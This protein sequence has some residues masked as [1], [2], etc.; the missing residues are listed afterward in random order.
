[1]HSDQYIRLEGAVVVTC[2]EAPGTVGVGEPKGACERRQP[3]GCRF[4]IRRGRCWCRKARLRSLPTHWLEAARHQRTVIRYRRCS[5]VR[6]RQ[7]HGCCQR[8]GTTR[9]SHEY[10]LD[11]RRSDEQEVHIIG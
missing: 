4:Y 1:D 3:C 6:E 10:V 9:I 7:R 8:R 2:I 5:I 11:T